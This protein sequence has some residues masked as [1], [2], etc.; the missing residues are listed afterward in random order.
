MTWLEMVAH[1]KG[2]RNLLQ[3]NGSPFNPIAWGSPKREHGP[4]GRDR[5]SLERPFAPAVL[6]VRKTTGARS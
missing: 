4:N 1:Y 2:Y 6:S 5:R 3:D